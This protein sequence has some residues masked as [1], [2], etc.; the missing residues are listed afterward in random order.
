GWD[1]TNVGLYKSTDYN[2]INAFNKSSG[3][4]QPH[5]NLQPYITTYIWLR[6][7]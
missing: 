7:A 5:N 2:Q 1:N 3:G 6:T 4:D